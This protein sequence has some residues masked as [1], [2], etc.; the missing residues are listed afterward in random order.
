MSKGVLK[1]ACSPDPTSGAAASERKEGLPGR[2]H[3]P[4]LNIREAAVS[5]TLA[6]GDCGP[7]PVVPLAQPVSGGSVSF[8]VNTT[9]LYKCDQGFVKIPGMPD[10]VVCLSS[11]K[12]TDIKEFCNRSCGAPPR[13]LYG[14]LKKIYISKNYFPEGTVLEYECRPGFRRIYPLVGKTTC[15][16]NLTWSTPD[17]FCE[18]KSCPTPRE[19]ENG[20]VSVATDILLGSQI[21][22]SCDPGYRLQGAASAFCMIVENGVDWSNAFGVCTKILCPQPPQIKNGQIID[23]R[24]TYEYR[25][26]ATYECDRGFTI[27]G[28]NQITCT[29]TDGTGE[30]SG[31]PPECK[32]KSPPPFIPPIVQKPTTTTVPDTEVSLPPQKASTVLPGTEDPVTPQ[33]PTTI[34]VPATRVRATPQKYTT[35]NV[36]ATGI[37][38]TPQKHTTVNVPATGIQPTPQ[39]HTTVNVPATG[40]QPTPQKHTTVNV[41]ATGIQPTPQKHTTVNVPATG[42]QPTPQKHTTVNVPDAE[43][44]PTPQKHTTVSGPDAE[45]SPTPQKTITVNISDTKAPLT[46]QKPS[47]AN[48]SATKVPAAAQSSPMPSVLSPV[49]TLAANTSA[50]QT[51]LTA[52]KHTTAEASF[53]QTLPARQKFTTKRVSGTQRFTSARITA[54]SRPP[55]SRMSTHPPTTASEEKGLSSSGSNVPDGG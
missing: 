13:L 25:Q 51:T 39:K 38:P 29:V 42:I 20:Q 30:W 35:V 34:N 47:T 12:W 27:I 14:I 41:P 9:V 31:P 44:S 55:I 5:V 1:G 49:T 48:S 33:K 4:E 8:P 50:T 19:I 17:V 36:P 6:R 37:Q 28:E 46:A 32:G 21:F 16:S 26:V 11:N 54:T 40:I 23:E 45:I 22:F 2:R 10:A 52:Q 53:T 18:K 7:L 43:V 15:L 3:D 24:D